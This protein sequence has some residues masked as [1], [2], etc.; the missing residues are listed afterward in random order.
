MKNEVRIVLIGESG[1]GKTSLILSL[2]S[3]EF[4]DE[5]PLRAEEITIPADVTP[6]RVP[7]IIVDCSCRDQTSEEISTEISK[8]DVVCIVYSVQDENSIF[9]IHSHWIPLVHQSQTD[10]TITKP[11]VFV[12][13]K[14]DMLES[15]SM[16]LIMPI[17]NEYA[18]I[19]TCVECSAKTLKNISEVF[20]YAQKAVLHPTAPLY[21]SEQRH[22]TSRCKE[23]LTRIFKIC[24]RDNDGLL[25]DDE[26]YQ[27]QRC[28]FN[29]PLQPQALEDVKC[30]VRRQ[31][32]GGIEHGMLTLNG[33][34]FLHKL[35][36]QRGRHE[37]T[38]T[39]LRRF[40]YD[41]GL[42]MMS[43]FTKPIVRVCPGSSTELSNVGLFFLSELFEKYDE[44]CDGCLSPTEMTNLSNLC[45]HLPPSKNHAPTN[46]H[47]WIT[48][49]GFLSYWNLMTYKDV[50]RALDFLSHTGF[51][52][53]HDNLISAINVTR[54][55]RIDI[56]K[57]QTRR[58]VF[59]CVV[60]GS[61]GCG[62]TAF[63]QGLLNRNLQYLK[64]LNPASLPSDTVNVVSVFGQELYLILQ[65][66]EGVQNIQ[67]N[68]DAVCLL[69]DVTNPQS[70]A[71]CANLYLQHFV[72][73]WIP[74]CI[75]GCKADNPATQQNY[76]LQ[77]PEFCLKHHLMPP[78]LITCS[79]K[80]NKEVYA[81]L[82]SLA[83]YPHIRKH[84]LDDD[85]QR[86][87]KRGLMISVAIGLGLV[88]IKYIRRMRS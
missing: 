1:V 41:D 38:W 67:Y 46:S 31:M 51:L 78:F 56:E 24:D 59:K 42:C 27:F 58:S 77:P 47:G 75:I 57:R 87:L 12:G 81:Q 39:V 43:E 17:M 48:H 63:L 62:K 36:V 16:D 19:E 76:H 84:S 35:F 64:T 18:E 30:V 22:L 21:N 44:D 70:F 4:P 55:K 49:Q 6:E 69:Y 2:I 85:P 9:K 71:Y 20:Y 14:S 54:D 86:W 3:E 40:G 15:S 33:F 68:S 60:A 25:N 79:E 45:P 34:L 26:I 52:Y 7:T 66:T 8:A 74:V 72:S 88:L 29:V 61:K 13:N 28:C 37:T 83:A 11:I 32:D 53:D 23:A 82:A 10:D 73:C 65:E 80:V 50:S 5:V